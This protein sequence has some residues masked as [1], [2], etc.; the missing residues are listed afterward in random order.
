MTVC[1]AYH[2]L[3]HSLRHPTRRH[4]RH[5]L[6]T[7]DLDK[8]LSH[9]AQDLNFI[10]PR[11]EITFGPYDTMNR[12][13]R[14]TS[15]RTNREGFRNRFGKTVEALESILRMRESVRRYSLMKATSAEFPSDCAPYTG[16]KIPLESVVLVRNNLPC[17][18]PPE[19]LR[20]RDI[21][22]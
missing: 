4:Y 14:S 18:T 13:A 21:I 2:F 19:V 12:L 16:V 15:D 20:Q 11:D 6:Q 9:H 1:R 8:H 17:Q 22:C 10:Y 3:Q 7:V 5:L